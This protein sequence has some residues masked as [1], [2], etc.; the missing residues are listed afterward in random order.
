M[1]FN[2]DPYLERYRVSPRKT[3][4]PLEGNLAMPTETPRKTSLA[5][6]ALRG[7][8]R[9]EEEGEEEEEEEEEQQQQQQQQQKQRNNWAAK[10]AVEGNTE[11][12]RF[13]NS[14]S[15]VAKPKI[16]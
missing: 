16:R 11:N 6:T 12:Q 3:K 14:Y 8:V 7:Y 13:I 1:F 4:Q 9:I 15:L 5:N 2:R 10:Q